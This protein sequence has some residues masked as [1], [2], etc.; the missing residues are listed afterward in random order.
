MFV[1]LQQETDAEQHAGVHEGVRHDAVHR[2][3]AHCAAVRRG[4]GQQPDHAHHRAR[5]S[6]A[7]TPLLSGLLSE[8]FAP[9]SIKSE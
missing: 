5:T 7:H 8:L 1:V 4:P 3:R 6:Q 2:P 9:G